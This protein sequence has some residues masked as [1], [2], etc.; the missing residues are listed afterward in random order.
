MIILPDVIY[1][2]AEMIEHRIPQ[3][4]GNKL[5]GYKEIVKSALGDLYFI[6][7]LH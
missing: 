7:D 5:E 1:L 3:Y 4:K 2:F 6:D